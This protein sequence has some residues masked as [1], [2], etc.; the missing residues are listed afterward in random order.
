MK[1]SYK[2][3]RFRLEGANEVIRTGLTLNEAQEHCRSE[4]T[5]KKDENNN[6]IWFDGYESEI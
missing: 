2:I 3:V 6:V 1:K 4:K 5:S